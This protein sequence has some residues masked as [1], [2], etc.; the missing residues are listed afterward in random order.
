[1]TSIPLPPL[2]KS[3]EIGLL[4]NSWLSW[5]FS[6]VELILLSASAVA[7]LWWLSYFP[8]HGL[9]CSA[10]SSTV[11][12]HT[13]QLVWLEALPLAQ[14][15]YSC[16]TSSLMLNVCLLSSSQHWICP[17]LGKGFSMYPSNAWC[18]H[19]GQRQ[20]STATFQKP[21]QERS[22]IPSTFPQTHARTSWRKAVTQ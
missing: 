17:G 18:E 21:L 13:L 2:P 14:A 22:A 3:A 15:I 19:Q 7:S 12:A 9:F 6:C 11:L 4:L 5:S 1:M 16:Y 20:C 8:V 10:H